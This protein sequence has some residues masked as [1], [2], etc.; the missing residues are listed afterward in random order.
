[1]TFEK[2]KIV[3]LQVSREK[4][5][6]EVCNPTTKTEEKNRDIKKESEG[7]VGD[8]QKATLE[9]QGEES[10]IFKGSATK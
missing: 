4:E 2:K 8:R 6:F 1:M 3:Q 7:R 9:K 10:G 5:V